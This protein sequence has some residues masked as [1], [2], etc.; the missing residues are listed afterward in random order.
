MTSEQK[1]TKTLKRVNED[2]L[3]DASIDDVKRPDDSLE[4]PD[5]IMQD[6]RPVSELLSDYS[7]CVHIFIESSLMV[8]IK[9]LCTKF[10][11]LIE[12]LPFDLVVSP[13]VISCGLSETQWR[14]ANYDTGYTTYEKYLMY[15][16]DDSGKKHK[17]LF[18]GIKLNGGLSY[19]K[20]FDVVYMI[21]NIIFIMTPDLATQFEFIYQVHSYEMEYFHRDGHSIVSKMRDAIGDVIAPVEP[22]SH[23]ID[24]LI[25]LFCT[26]CNV[27]Y[28]ES[29]KLH[30]DGYKD[31][32][33]MMRE[34]MRK[35]SA[36]H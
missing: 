9:A 16:T 22:N 17:H 1:Y 25:E 19:T 33:Y 13:V 30:N 23:P 34:H 12:R 2:F 7:C 21:S 26:I 28:R 24:C 18:M 8:R 14:Y 31:F 20:A 36:F 11:Q 27:S 35:R 3:D 32:I 10:R 4:N 5:Y 29:W 6:G 15:H